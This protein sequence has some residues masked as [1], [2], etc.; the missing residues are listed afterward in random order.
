MFKELNILK[1]FLESPTKEFNV[2]EV[3]RLLE[4]TPATASKDLKHWAKKGIL[5][6]RKERIY[7]L[8]KSNLDSEVYRDFK[9]Y[10]NT[11]KIKESGLLESLNQF[12]LKP[13][14]ILFGS[15]AQGLDVEESDF[16]L[17][18]ITEKNKEFPHQNTYEKKINRKLQL[19]VIRELK[20][21]KNDHLINNIINGIVI[22]GELKWI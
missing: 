4:I 17:V 14:I 7:Q 5:K 10:Y 12:Y 1:I 13:T 21:L 9:R 11:Q 15:A 3:A 20:E 16:D 19:F 6:F 2:R 18:I 22:Q 8:Y